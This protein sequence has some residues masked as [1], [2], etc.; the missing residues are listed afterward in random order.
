MGDRIEANYET[1]ENVSNI[2]NQN[3][4][5]LK[6]MLQN[7]RSTM[8]TLRSEGWIGRGSD[9]F[10]SEMTDEVLPMV[11]RLVEAM[12]EASSATRRIASTIEEA[13]DRAS[14][15]FRS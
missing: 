10:Y 14:G 5:V 9:A 15:F 2:F 8:E 7:V 11:Q 12:E 1:L 6:S 13:E 4:E 3:H